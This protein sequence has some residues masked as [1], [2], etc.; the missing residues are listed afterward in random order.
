MRFASFFLLSLLAAAQSGPRIQLSHTTEALRGVSAVSRDVAWASGTHG[1]Y[2]RTTDARRTWTPAQVPDATTL[3]FRAVVAFSA[4]E[5][6]LM[7]AGP[8]DLSRIYHT[9]DAGQHWQLQFANT[10]PKG[11][12]DSMAF[13]DPKHGIVLG[14]PVPD[15]SGKLK[16]EVLLTDDGQ[17]W[18]AIPPAQLPNALE[19]EGAFA[20]SNSCIAILSGT[21][22]EERRGRVSGAVEQRSAD[23]AGTAVEARRFSAASAAQNERA[24]APDPNIWFATGG[25]TARVFHSP[26]RGQT[27]QVFDTPILH[28]PE[29][30]GI[31]SIAFRDPQHGVIAGGDYKHP[32]DDGPNLAFTNDGGKTWT[33]SDI[34]PQA[35]FSAIAYDR[36][37]NEA[38]AEQ[39]AEQAAAEAKGKKLRTQPITPERL[40]IIGQDFVFDL[41]PPSN[42]HRL[43]GNKKQPLAFNAASPYPE[44]GALIVGPKGTIVFFP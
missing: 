39:K 19:G 25:K 43:S 36:K 4:D 24:S 2:L 6:F 18:H 20:A 14:D 27:W 16:F 35:Y 7:S 17:T 42:P 5:A 12:F 38:A 41:R 23:A 26:D 3:D 37:V 30:A 28:G 8:G 9:T 44:G 10:N 29:S 40:F 22:V 31:F 1:T 33:L 32:N 21:A 34:K 11:F 15:E 13:W